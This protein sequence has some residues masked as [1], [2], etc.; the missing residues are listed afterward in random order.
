METGL[1]R[2]PSPSAALVASS[3]ALSFRTG[4]APGSARHTGQVL[5]LGAAPKSVE[6]PQNA[7]V[8]VL[9]CT[10][11]SSPTT[12]SYRSLIAPTGNAGVGV[13]GVKIAC[14]PLANTERKS[15]AMSVRTAC[16]F[17]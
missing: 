6:Q 13:V 15:S 7:F 17:L 1:T 8:R 3:T 10:C 14:T 4:N 9:S 16:A 11:T 5:T 2:H 12:I